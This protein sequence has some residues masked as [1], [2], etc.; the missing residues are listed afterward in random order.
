[1]A[2]SSEKDMKRQTYPQTEAH[3]SDVLPQDFDAGSIASFFADAE[4]DLRGTAS[5]TNAQ[6][7]ARLAPRRE[8]ATP[9]VMGS[10]QS[11]LKVLRDA[12]AP[13]PVDKAILAQA[14]KKFGIEMDDDDLDFG[15]QIFGKSP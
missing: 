5:Q 2:V 14:L 11:V 7:M 12:G 8:G 4:P 1:M 3:L 10:A 6:A 15:V 13:P 9:K